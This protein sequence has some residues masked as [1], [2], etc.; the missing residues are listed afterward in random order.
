MRM[1]NNKRRFRLAIWGIG[2]AVVLMLPVAS[3]ALL[4]GSHSWHE[5]LWL[6]LYI[7]V[8][9]LAVASVLASI[10]YFYPVMYWLAWRSFLAMDWLTGSQQGRTFGKRLMHDDFLLR[11]SPG[12]W[13]H[14]LRRKVVEHSGN[15]PAEQDAL[16]NDA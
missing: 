8:W 3:L 4:A 15:G 12:T 10:W 1:G 11:S 13:A 14:W 2:T 7:L 16:T 9:P 6:A 5:R